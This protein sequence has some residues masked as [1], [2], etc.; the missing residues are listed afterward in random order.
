[1]IQLTRPALSPRATKWLKKYQNAVNAKIGFPA[2][3]SFAKSDFP[4][5]NVIKNA[6]FEEVK[7]KLIEMC[8]GAE[9][10]HYCEDSKA[11]E[12][13]H[14]FP[15]DAYPDL[16]YDWNNYL[17][18]CGQC[19]VRKNNK[20][21]VIDPVSNVITDNTPP[22]QAKTPPP[23][24]PPPPPSP[25]TAGQQAFIDIGV[26]DPLDFFLLDLR[27][28]SFEFAA[29]PA[30]GT[31]E[32]LR[33]QYTL[34]TLQLKERKFLNEAR[35]QAYGNYKARLRTYIWDRDNG[36]AQPLLDNMIEE[37]KTHSHPTVWKE[38]IRQ[39][40]TIPE[41]QALFNQAPEALTW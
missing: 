10:C 23:S 41:L 26:E 39:R 6:T 30:P 19:N 35:R 38:M 18:S 25:P 4:K 8:S 24:P 7:L 17:Y 21:G 5:K 3:V 27:Y 9:R 11:D 34:E 22:K 36:V 1:M 20:C 33:A 12:V 14:I 29:L 2:Q 16:C 13:E 28:G 15:K 37:I 31:P 40:S 32:Y